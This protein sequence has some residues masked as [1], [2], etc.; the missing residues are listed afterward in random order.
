VRDHGAD[1]RSADDARAPAHR[2]GEEPA[3]ELDWIDDA[4]R[5]RPKGSVRRDAVAVEHVRLGEIL[6]FEAVLVA[7]LGFGTEATPVAP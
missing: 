7:Q 2:L 5:G 4:R 3:S 6:H 1:Q